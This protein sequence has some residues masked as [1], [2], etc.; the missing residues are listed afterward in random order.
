MTATGSLSTVAND[1]PSLTGHHSGIRSLFGQGVISVT[2]LAPVKLRPLAAHGVG[3]RGARLAFDAKFSRLEAGTN[4]LDDG[5][6]EVALF[7]IA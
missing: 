5:G 2:V 6:Q 4:A 1:S 3:G 7:Y